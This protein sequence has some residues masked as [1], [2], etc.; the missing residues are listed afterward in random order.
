MS[1]FNAKLLHFLFNI[2]STIK[3]IN[4]VFVWGLEVSPKVR[5]FLWRLCTGTFPVCS[6]L[7]KRHLLDNA[8]CPRC[9][10]AD[11]TD[12]HSIFTYPAIKSLW[13]DCDCKPLVS[14]EDMENLQELIAGWDSLDKKM[15]QREAFLAWNL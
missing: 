15:V 10:N 2:L 13:E 12:M 11:E 5:H 7:M 9:N 14:E 3:T 1:K 4:W 8:M 6:L